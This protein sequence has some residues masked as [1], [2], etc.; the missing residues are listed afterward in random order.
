ML[1]TYSG[2]VVGGL[3]TTVVAGGVG[4]VVGVV[5][6]VPGSVDAVVSG[7]D[8]HAVSP[9]RTPS[10]SCS[11]ESGRTDVTHLARRKS[12]GVANRLGKLQAVC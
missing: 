6:V 5:R 10:R 8:G 4:V 9:T 2:G 12:P 1:G 3:V 11:V 7:L